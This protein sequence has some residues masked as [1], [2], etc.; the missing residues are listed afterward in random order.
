MGIS[1]YT[2]SLADVQMTMNTV[3]K[4]NPKAKIV[5][6][7]PHCAMFPDY[8]IQLKGADAIITGDG[9]D[10]FVEMAEAYDQGKSW[11]AFRASGSRTEG[12]SS[13]T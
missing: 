3:R 1:T 13:R 2:H 12:R 4:L 10:A 11:E 7:G 6:G 8:A 5:L 9:E